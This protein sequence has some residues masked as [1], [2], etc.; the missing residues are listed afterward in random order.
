[1]IIGSQV[2]SSVDTAIVRFRQLSEQDISSYL[3]TG[4]WRGRAGGYAIQETG[5]RFA[6]SIEGSFDTVIGLPMKLVE[7]LLAAA[8][9]AD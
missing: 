3:D 6:E 5:D 1:V 4:E 2:V 9:Q 7:S 8:V